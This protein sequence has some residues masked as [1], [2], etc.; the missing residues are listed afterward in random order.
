M[1]GV[2]TVVKDSNKSCIDSIL[3]QL[4]KLNKQH[5]IHVLKKGEK[6][7]VFSIIGREHHEVEIHS[8]I[9]AE[10]LNPEGLH[11]QGDVFLKSFLK[12]EKIV[13]KY[14]EISNREHFDD[15]EVSKEFSIFNNNGR[16]DILIQTYDT[17]IAIENKIYAPDQ[18]EQLKR[19]NDFSKSPVIYLTLDGGEPGESTRGNLSIDEV[20]CL[21]YEKDIVGWLDICIEEVRRLPQIRVIL[22]QYQKLVKSLTGQSIDREYDMKAADIFFEGDNYKII[23]MLETSIREFKIQLQRNF[24]IDLQNKIKEKGFTSKIYAKDGTK[25][26]E[27]L[28]HII[29]DVYTHNTSRN[30]YYGITIFPCSK[31]QS[32]YAV[33]V[34]FGYYDT[35]YWGL[36]N[37]N[38]KIMSKF[39]QENVNEILEECQH[40][41]RGVEKEEEKG[42]YGYIYPTYDNLIYDF[43]FKEESLKFIYMMASEEMRE[44]VVDKLSED[45]ETAIIS[46]KKKLSQQ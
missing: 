44:K 3:M 10:L 45:I 14:K 36:V 38:S 1:I 12:S 15:F 31:Q 37:R 41:P 11:G 5:E 24:W 7:N 40:D 4:K 19:Y 32:E 23:P 8:A 9:I 13:G 2:F 20:I 30:R 16:I 27:E 34:E 25:S 46:T 26:I 43:S 21:S 22:I 35:I 6:F 17:C 29:R 18:N 28:N 42:W 33:Q 39:L